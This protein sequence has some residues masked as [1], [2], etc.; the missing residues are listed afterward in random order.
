MIL[1]CRTIENHDVA[2]TQDHL[3]IAVL[4]TYAILVFSS[5]SI[6]LSDSFQ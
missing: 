3:N 1:E 2:V 4:E 5:Q 6:P